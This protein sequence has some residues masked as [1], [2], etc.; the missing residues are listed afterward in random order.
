[1]DDA[2][3]R[4]PDE[5]SSDRRAVYRGRRK[6]VEW[7]E[8]QDGQCE[9]YKQGAPRR[10]R[11]GQSPHCCLPFKSWSVGDLQV[12]PKALRFSFAA[13]IRALA[14]TIQSAS[15]S[16]PAG[17]R[18]ASAWASPTG[19]RDRAP[20]HSDGPAAELDRLV[21][22]AASALDTVSRRPRRRCGLPQSALQW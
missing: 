21:D 15:N 8:A 13:A 22:I 6:V 12:S 3:R 7:R 14:T 18:R 9:Q 4:G 19:P 16:W 5:R 20:R 2:R 10:S 1:L 17:R 11:A